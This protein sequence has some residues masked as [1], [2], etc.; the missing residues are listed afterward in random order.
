MK[1]NIYIKI[2]IEEKSILIDAQAV[3]LLAKPCP[4]SMYLTEMYS[5][6]EASRDPDVISFPT[7]L[8]G[9]PAGSQAVRQR[10]GAA[11]VDGGR[12]AGFWCLAAD[13]GHCADS[14]AHLR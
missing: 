2:M 13:T 9:P 12:S 5:V 4:S 1:P 3:Q 10:R 7:D 8:P 6:D 14:A 11:L